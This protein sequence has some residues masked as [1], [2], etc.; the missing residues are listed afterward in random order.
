MGTWPTRTAAA[1]AGG[2][3]RVA[4]RTV[5]GGGAIGWWDHDRVRV[6]IRVAPARGRAVHQKARKPVFE[7]ISCQT[8]LRAGIKF[9]GCIEICFAN[10]NKEAELGYAAGLFDG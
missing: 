2:V 5:R 8:A 9:T 1:A 6:R 3:G 4:R 10:I 7:R